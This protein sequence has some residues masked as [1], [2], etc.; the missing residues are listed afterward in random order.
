MRT[1]TK[2]K[3][4][5][6]NLRNFHR[7]HQRLPFERVGKPKPDSAVPDKQHRVESTDGLEPDL[8]IL[9][10]SKKTFK[11]GIASR[12]KPFIWTGLAAMLIISSLA[13]MYVLDTRAKLIAAQ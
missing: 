11:P 8:S 2:R 5:F 10:N 12:L 6:N 13:L 9:N 3:P 4:S 1:G 7:T